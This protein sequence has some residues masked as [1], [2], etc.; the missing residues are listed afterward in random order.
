MRLPQQKLALSRYQDH[1]LAIQSAAA[2]ARGIS[3]SSVPCP[4]CDIGYQLCKQQG[5]GF[6]CDIAYQICRKN[7]N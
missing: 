5:G 6:A 2:G 1:S 7:C 3:M 4:V